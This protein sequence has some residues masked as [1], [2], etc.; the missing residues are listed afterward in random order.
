VEHERDVDLST[1]RAYVEALGGHLEL[2]AVFPDQTITLGG[3]SDS[4]PPV[5]APP[6]QQIA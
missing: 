5:T 2:R 3:L 4:S 6:G 1:L